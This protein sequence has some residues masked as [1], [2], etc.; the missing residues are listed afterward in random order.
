[1][2]CAGGGRWFLIAAML[3]AALWFTAG[4]RPAAA[5]E[6]GRTLPQMTVAFADDESFDQQIGGATKGFVRELRRYW[7]TIG[8]IFNKAAV[9]WGI[10][11]KRIA[12]SLVVAIVAALAD[13]GLINVW[14]TEGTRALTTY[15][16]L[17]LYVYGRLLFARGVS[18][19]PKL[20]LLGAIVYGVVRNDFL[21][22]RHLLRG[23]V[24]DVILIVVAARVFVYACPQP[25]IDSFAARAINWRQRLAGLQQRT[26]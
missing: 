25:L 6:V 8:W 3:V 17:M 21:P 12:F 15:V 5:A 24:E 13:S 23:R 1:M 16:P 2:P 26:R 9:W 7:R 4:V 22:D 18:L 19:A 10:W 20:F 11:L 14:R